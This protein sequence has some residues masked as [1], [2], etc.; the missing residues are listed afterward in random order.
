MLNSSSSPSSASATFALQ[1]GRLLSQRVRDPN[2]VELHRAT[3]DELAATN[4]AA[5]TLLWDNWQLRA[6]NT[7]L[8][9]GDPHTL[10]LLS[11]MAA[12]GVKQISFG[13]PTDR[14]LLLGV[15]WILAQEPKIGD[16]G[17]NAISRLRMLGDGSARMIPVVDSEGSG[18]TL[19]RTSNAP[20]TQSTTA[21]AVLASANG[22]AASTTE[23]VNADS[24]ALAPLVLEPEHIETAGPLVARL[25]VA[26]AADEVA[27]ALAAMAA[28]AEIPGRR[29]EDVVALLAALMDAEHRLSGDEARR[30]L[31]AGTRRVA[32]PHFFR[33]M[34]AALSTAPERHDAYMRI[35]AHFG[36]P[37]VDE[38]IEQL[39][40]AES[41]KERRV[42]FDAVVELKR[43][44][45]T[46]IYL[47]GDGRWYVVRNAADLLGEMRAT[48]AEPGLAWLLSHADQRVRRS[49]TSALAKLETPG[50]RAA[51]KQAIRDESRDVRL[52][53]MIALA[54]TKE[55]GAVAIILRALSEESDPDV[56]RT[57]M[58]TLARIG[59][60]EAVQHLVDVAEPAAGLF[61]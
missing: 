45:P 57:L 5:I 40:H 21:A 27:R 15:V 29:I 4:A 1:F 25:A 46:L 30:V 19:P 35:F 61:K 11:R 50:A 14:A 39:A 47:L 7:L 55:R 49:A 32:R 9:A 59:T 3:L 41:S 12:H 36:D 24:Q 52:H 44:V 17:A 31:V 54:A 16:G 6:G 37:A 26:T 28:F 23:S 48:E 60:P 58:A 20:A 2:N 18:E 43:G 38:L 13:N 33:A 42:L 53:A 34:A 22:S 10:D 8:T 56:Q 51:L